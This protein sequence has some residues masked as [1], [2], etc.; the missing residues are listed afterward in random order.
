MS[1]EKTRYETDAQAGKLQV[2]DRGD[3]RTLYLGGLPQTTIDVREPG[4]VVADYIGF[5]HLGLLLCQRREHAG[6]LGLGGGA[7]VHS[8]RDSYPGMHMTAVELD[9]DVAEVARR[10]FYVQEDEKLSVVVDDARSFLMRRS[11][12]FDL[13]VLD[14]YDGG[15]YPA[16]LYTRESFSLMSQALR[17]GSRGQPCGAVAVNAVG[18]LRGRQSS[19]VKIIKTLTQVFPSVYLFAVRQSFWRRLFGRGNNYILFAEHRSA[20]LARQKLQSRAEQLM[21][22]TDCSAD[23]VGML[24]EQKALPPL[25]N[26]QVLTDRDVRRGRVTLSI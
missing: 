9:P 1:M 22:K 5:F 21:M 10:Y 18:N 25:E 23:L 14:A 3:E 19:V 15:G 8:L 24:K 16:R 20:P 12:E 17:T 11:D 13:L 26:V 7:A 6:L 4:R 2:V